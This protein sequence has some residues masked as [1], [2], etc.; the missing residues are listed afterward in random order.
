MK[1]MDASPTRADAFASSNDVCLRHIIFVDDNTKQPRSSR[2]TNFIQ[3][4][5]QALQL[6]NCDGVGVQVV[7]ESRRR[8]ELLRLLALVTFLV[9]TLAYTE[10]KV[11]E[12]KID[13]AFLDR[14]EESPG[15]SRLAGW[16]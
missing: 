7:P 14:G 16:G 2:L 9:S 8:H 3:Y 11:Q 10:L 15:E 12:S 13:E 4:T 6:Y 5:I 1:M